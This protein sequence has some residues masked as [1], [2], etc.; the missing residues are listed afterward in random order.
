MTL[1]HMG[2]LDILAKSG[3]DAL[4]FNFLLFFAKCAAV[5][6]GWNKCDN[7]RKIICLYL[8]L[9]LIVV[10]DRIIFGA[11]WCKIY[12]FRKNDFAR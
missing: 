9:K 12:I 10:E 1:S 3:C 6:L 8:S 2:M 11:T 4:V 5:C 7:H